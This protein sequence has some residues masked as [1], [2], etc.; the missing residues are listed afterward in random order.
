[1]KSKV[2]IK[3]HPIHPIL[4]MFP[5]AFFTGT[6]LFD[7]LAIRTQNT[8]NALIAV[9]LQE[10]GM[11][12]AVVAAFA[13]VM[14]YM[15]TIPPKSSGKKR[16]M[17]HGILNTANL[18]LF[19]IAWLIKK[20]PEHNAAWPIALES[21]G[22]LIL[23][24]AGWLGGTLV[25]RNQIGVDLRYADAGKWNEQYISSDAGADVEVAT[26][27]ELKK[28]QMKLIH[29]NDRRIVIGRTDKGFVAFDDRCCHKGGSLAAGA[30]VCG[31]VQCPWHGSQFD[32]ASGK[33]IAGPAKEG[34]PV[35][36]AVEKDGKVFVRLEKK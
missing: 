36:Y 23:C 4:V 28:G 3:G 14:D 30:L 5:V 31:I 27:D 19:F 15:Y 11:F 20:S 25:Y 12:T 33:L 32:T 13:G 8:E 10:I 7:L 21:V 9:S 17:Q 16:G 29:V 35:Y 6:L 26:S 24:I 18:L 2:S 22:F 1:M 34:I